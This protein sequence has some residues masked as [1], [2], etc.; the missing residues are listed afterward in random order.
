MYSTIQVV[1]L[2]ELK[3]K[4]EDLE[5][6]VSSM[7]V[8]WYNPITQSTFCFGHISSRYCDDCD[9]HWFIDWKRVEISDPK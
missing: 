5:D 9:R 7:S 1:L 4:T 6:V 8:Y 2:S 3:R